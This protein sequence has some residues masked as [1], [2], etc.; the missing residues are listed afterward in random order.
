[1]ITWPATIVCDSFRDFPEPCEAT[2][3]VEMTLKTETVYE[4]DGDETINIVEA[5]RLPEG[6]QYAST[7]TRHYC[8]KHNR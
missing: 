1:M 6:W 7:D 2:G 3:Q 4:D 5:V 8:P